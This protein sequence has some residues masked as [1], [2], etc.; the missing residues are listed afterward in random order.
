M[1]ASSPE[2]TPF[3]RNLRIFMSLAQ[4][5]NLAPAKNDLVVLNGVNYK[6]ADVQS[7]DYNGFF[8]SLRSA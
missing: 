5:G 3:G 6:V 2:A 7:N 4:A 8:L 1:P